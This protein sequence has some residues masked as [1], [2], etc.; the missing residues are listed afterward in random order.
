MAAL[1]KNLRVFISYARRDASAFAEELLCG[2][3]V[4]GFEAFLDRHDIAAGEDWE[5]RLGGLIQSA[6]TVVFVVTPA[7]VASERCA[8]EV[9]RAEALS[10][11]IIP[12]VAIPVAEGDT[13]A[14]LTRLNYIFFTEGHSFSRSLGDL[15]TALR[16]DLDWIREH[17]RLGDLAR[18]WRARDEADVLLLRGSELDAAQAWLAAWKAPAPEPTDLH[19]AFIGESAATHSATMRRERTRQ[20]RTISALIAVAVVFAGLTIASGLLWRGALNAETAMRDAVTTAFTIAMDK[21]EE[22]MDGELTVANLRSAIASFEQAQSLPLAPSSRIEAQSRLGDAYMKLAGM[23]GAG[24]SAAFSCAPGRAEPSLLQRAREINVLWSADAPESAEASYAVGCTLRALGQASEAVAHLRVAVAREPS[25]PDYRLALARALAE[26]GNA[27]DSVP[28]FQQALALS[29]RDVDVSAAI[30]TEIA[31]VQMK[32]NAARAEQTLNAI[33]AANPHYAPAF[34]QRGRLYVEHMPD[35]E[36]NLRRA[37]SDLQAAWRRA[38]RSPSPDAT[39]AEAFY[40]LS[41]IEIRR[42][43]R[44]YRHNAEAAISQ[45]DRAIR[46]DPVNTLYWNQAC[47]ARTLVG[48]EKA[49]AERP[50][51]CEHQPEFGAASFFTEGLFYLSQAYN[52]RSTDQRR[53]QQRDW[54]FAFE[55]FTTG[56]GY[57]DSE[58]DDGAANQELRAR[59]I[60]GRIFALYCAGLDNAVDR[61]AVLDPD[62]RAATRHYFIT[63]GLSRCWR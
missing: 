55:R 39:A 52:K 56:L 2:L 50:L 49:K 38:A 27:G 37:E 3:E 48:D 24:R 45:A 34:V 15:A 19:R 22:A 23:L 26:S 58:T 17:T 42:F 8:W 9:Q 28:E 32:N 33:L 29:P 35:S 1:D 61:D 63:Q 54:A 21:G 36:E 31:G 57:V 4:A 7:A 5:A 40:L 11:R 44:G 43:Q 16:V 51:Y 13:P 12:I 41:Q 53:D 47:A 20:R 59:L 46:L 6:D 14:S 62:L 60:Y 18:R 10:K 30:Q 25:Q